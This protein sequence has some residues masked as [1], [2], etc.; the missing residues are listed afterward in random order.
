M[1]VL[2]GFIGTCAHVA[3]YKE[4]WELWKKE[5]SKVYSSEREEATREA[6]WTSNRVYVETHNA[7]AH[8]HG[9]TLAMNKFADLVRFSV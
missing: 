7:N 8:I 1:I 9:F 3:D 2:V 5:H 6:I 4:E